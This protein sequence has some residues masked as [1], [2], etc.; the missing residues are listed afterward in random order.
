MGKRAPS[1]PNPQESAAAQGQIN[2]DTARVQAR[3]NRGNTITPFGTVTNREIGPDQWE[4]RVE[5]SPA[6]QRIMGQGE[7]LDLE[8]GQLS[9]DM[10]PEARRV[11]M[12][13]MAMDD[14]DARD[15]A[16]AGFM[17]RMEPQFARDREALEGRLIAQGFQ[18]GTEAYRRAADE[19]NRSVTDARMQAT[20]AG[21]GESRNAAA[22]SNAMRGQRINELG[23][24]FGLGPG[25]QMPQ[26]SQMAGVGME[27]PNLMGAIQ[28]NYA[29]RAGQ[30]GA[31]MGALGQL[32]GAALGGWARGGFPLTGTAVGRI[33]GMG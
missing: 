27:A 3:L 11:L 9:L 6:Q 21:L 23:M 14:F 13:P 28:S 10:L 17:S 4:S 30:Y 18:P 20:T 7:A 24:L 1:A 5:L 8:T 2:T 32:G 31:N 26:Q 12:Q 25:M 19:L 33:F 15:R 29:A 22:F 16:T